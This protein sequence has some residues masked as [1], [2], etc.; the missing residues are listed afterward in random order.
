MEKKKRIPL[1]PVII[2]ILV[3]VLALV[4]SVFVVQGRTTDDLMGEHQ[5]MIAEHGNVTQVIAGEAKVKAS[6]TVHI[7]LD[8]PQKVDRIYVEEGE[9]VTEGQILIEYDIT[10]NADKYARQL[11]EA[12]YSLSSANLTLSS[13]SQ[14][15][16]G[17]DLLQ[18]ESAVLTAQKSITDTIGEIESLES[19]LTQQRLRARNLRNTANTYRDDYRD[20]LLSEDD[21]ESART[22]SWVAEA[23]IEDLEAQLETAKLALETRERQLK[24]AENRLSNAQNPL[25]NDSTA[26]N[27]QIQKNVAAINTLSVTNIQSEMNKL[28][29][30]TICP[31]SGNVTAINCVE[32]EMAGTGSAIITINNTQGSIVRFE[33]N[34]FDAPKVRVGQKALIRM[35]GMADR[36]YYGTVIKIA[37]EAVAKDYSDD[38]EIVVPIEISINNCDDDLRIGYTVDVE[39]IVEETSDVL[40]IPISTVAIRGDAK[41]VYVIQDNELI[42]REVKTGFYGDKTVE[43]KEGL[44]EGEKIILTPYK[45][46]D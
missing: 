23:G 40:S 19:Q 3:L 13:I 15:A 18:Y 29:E 17:N 8:L 37:S 44:A 42:E 32:G 4:V 36:E 7:F 10:Q 35:A 14:P 45:L 9:R 43:I 31:I 30:E 34:E 5:F 27:Y 41:Y 21:Y 2:L 39:L 33:V 26:L 11:A 38:N 22:N 20:D 1:K 28:I 6:D 25:S 24:I 46:T 12:Q 16:T